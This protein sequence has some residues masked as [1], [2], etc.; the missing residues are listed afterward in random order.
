MKGS[1][2]IV[3]F[4]ET[5]EVVAKFKSL[6]SFSTTVGFGKS[7]A[8][9]ALKDPKFKLHDKDDYHVDVV[10]K[11]EYDR[12]LLS[13]PLVAAFNEACAEYAVGAVFSD[14]VFDPSGTP[15]ASF[16]KGELAKFLGIVNK[17]AKNDRFDEPTEDDNNAFPLTTSSKIWHVGEWTVVSYANVPTELTRNDVSLTAFEV[18]ARKSLDNLK[19][20]SIVGQGILTREQCETTGTVSFFR[21]PQVMHDMLDEPIVDDFI[22]AA[23]RIR[24]FDIVQAGNERFVSE[25]VVAAIE[26]LMGR[27][28]LEKYVPKESHPFWRFVGCFKRRFN[29]NGVLDM[30]FNIDGV[31][32]AWACRNCEEIKTFGYENLVTCKPCVRSKTLAKR[33]REPENCTNCNREIDYSGTLCHFCDNTKK[34]ANGMTKS[35]RYREKNRDNVEYKAHLAARLR[36]YRKNNPDIMNAIEAKRA[37]DPKRRMYNIKK[38]AGNGGIEFVEADELKLMTLLHFPCHWC[39]IQMGKLQGLDRLDN[40]GPYALVNV[41]PSCGP[42]NVKRRNMPPVLFPVHISKMA[43]RLDISVPDCRTELARNAMSNKSEDPDR[44]KDDL[45]DTQRQLLQ[46]SACALCGVAP[47]MGIDR[48]DNSV[49]YT[50]ENSQPCCSKCNYIK[51]TWPMTDLK[52][53]IGNVIFNINQGLVDVEKYAHVVAF[54]DLPKENVAE[55]I[56]EIEDAP[57]EIE[58]IEAMF[59]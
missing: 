24:D 37:M 1:C 40:D 2:V 3:R 13:P 47:A 5:N 28:Q 41:V 16:G 15:I 25:I 34:D 33:K 17:D 45:T 22:D 26:T 42:C 10:N 55:A 9:N 50:I 59:G 52:I 20:K 54:A 56:E 18:V 44:K 49:H 29:V 11:G 23:H 30:R 46:K 43:A 31:P 38:R 35:Q 19:I 39:G 27:L 57:E 7:W 4:A 21:L 6:S 48:I 32:F 58:D 8:S 51:H 36:E 12:A 14:T 53:W